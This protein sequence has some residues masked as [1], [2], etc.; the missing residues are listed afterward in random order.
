MVSTAA[1][2]SKWWPLHTLRDNH[3]SRTRGPEE[4]DQLFAGVTSRGDRTHCSHERNVRLDL[5]RQWPSKLH[6]RSRQYLRDHDEAK[7]DFSAGRER[8]DAVAFRSPRL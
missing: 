5:R 1:V 7:L 3:S 4:P 6:S 2:H 8:G